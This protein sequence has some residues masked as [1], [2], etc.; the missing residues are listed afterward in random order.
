M[1]CKSESIKDSKLIIRGVFYMYMKDRMLKPEQ[2]DKLEGIF[3]AI[4]ECSNSLLV[5][6]R[7]YE[8][9]FKCRP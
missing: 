3:N 2:V 9:L 7:R 6:R 4:L 1:V 5:E 8:D